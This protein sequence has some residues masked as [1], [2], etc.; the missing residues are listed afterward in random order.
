MSRPTK[1]PT[2]RVK[3]ERDEDLEKLR[4]VCAY[5]NLGKFPFPL[6]GPGFTLNG[7][8][9][10]DFTPV[11]KALRGLVKEWQ[12]SG[13][14]IEVMIE[15]NPALWEKIQ[16]VSIELRPTNTGAVRVDLAA[17]PQEEGLSRFDLFV[18]SFFLLLTMNPY[19]N[20]LGGPCARCLN[21]Y[22]KKTSRQK[23]YCSKRCGLMETSIEANRRRGSGLHKE[24]VE[25]ALGFI[26]KWEFTR[27]K[28]PWKVWVSEKSGYSRTWLTRAVTRGDLHEPGRDFR[29]S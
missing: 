26:S 21:Y 24:K 28:Q 10:W 23:V 1:T 7:Y 29:F 16:R 2:R 4:Q 20:R 17:V 27:T 3:Q 19:W 25:K 8:R 12:D 18:Y 5:L 14:N 9:T 6:I 13:P 15:R 22:V 11:K